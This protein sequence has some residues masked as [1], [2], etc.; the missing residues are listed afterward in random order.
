[1]KITKKQL[2]QI[3]EEEIVS[4]IDENIVKDADEESQLEENSRRKRDL[5]WYPKNDPVGKLVFAIQELTRVANH[6]ITEDDVGAKPPIGG[7]ISQI[8]MAI[9]Q[10]DNLLDI[11]RQEISQLKNNKR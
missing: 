5:T 3:I 6:V 9:D 8:G 1:M 4:I 2:T 10:I 7:A 11:Y